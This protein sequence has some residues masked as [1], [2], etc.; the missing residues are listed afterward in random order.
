L[1]KSSR[2]STSK[3]ATRWIV[4]NYFSIERVIGKIR[5]ERHWEPVRKQVQIHH[6]KEK[7]LPPPPTK[8]LSYYRPAEQSF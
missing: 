3:L 8:N 2:K 1:R 7:V 4:S 6:S 5:F